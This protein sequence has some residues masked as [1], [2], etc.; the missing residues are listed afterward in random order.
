MPSQLGH[1]LAGVC[2]YAIMRRR[3]ARQ[4]SAWLF[5]GSILMANL[6]DLDLLISILAGDYGR[7]HGGPTHSLT[8][9]CI[10]GSLGIVLG[11]FCTNESVQ[12]GIWAA[13]LYSSHVLLDLLGARV[14]LFWP[15]SPV[16]VG[17]WL[18]IFSSLTL[19]Q[20]VLESFAP[21]V[22]PILLRKIE[23]RLS[24][25]LFM[26]PVVVVAWY[27]AFRLARRS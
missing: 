14:Q 20:P 15:F 4:R 22:N 26:T 25:L 1:A 24:E 17:A 27:V 19:F 6:A 3:V 12:W 8:A 16:P 2:G 10:A 21:F 5:M 9:V 23:A 11:R 13:G 18:P 7:F